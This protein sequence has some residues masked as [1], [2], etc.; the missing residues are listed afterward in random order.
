MDYDARNFSDLATTPL[1]KRLWAFLN[2]HDNVIRMET[3]SCLGRPAVEPLG[4]L[5]LDKFGDKVREHRVKQMIG[6]M[7]RQILEARGYVVD[8]QGA[9][10][11]R[12]G[13]PF[14]SGTRYT[15]R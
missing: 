6:H 9:R 13:N 15:R 4:P 3:A 1:G 12:P 2:E 14:S 5:V 10:I 11:T 8:R 7:T